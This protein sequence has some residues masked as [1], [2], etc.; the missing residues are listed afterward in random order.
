MGRRDQN[1]KSYPKVCVICSTQNQ[2]VNYI[3]LKMNK[4]DFG[5]IYNITV[6]GSTYF[7]NATWDK[8][9][10]A[11]LNKTFDDI[12]LQQG[13]THSVAKIL[14]NKQLESLKTLG[15]PIFW[16]ITGGQRTI[17]LS[18]MEIIKSNDTRNNDVIC[19]LE[20]NNNQMYISDIHHQKADVIDYS[21]EEFDLD[22]TKALKLG[23]F[24]ISQVKGDENHIDENSLKNFITEYKNTKNGL[25]DLMI[26]TNTNMTQDEAIKKLK[27]LSCQHKT[28]IQRVIEWGY[29]KNKSTPFGYILEEMTYYVIKESKYFQNIQELKTN[30]RLYN[31]EKIAEINNTQIDEFDVLLLTKNGKLMVFECKSGS[32]HRDIAKSTNYSTYAVSGVYGLPILITPLLQAEIPPKGTFQNLG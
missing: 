22:I 10:K 20:G 19:Y 14:E 26:E 7:N 21:K 16:N 18:I 28:E 24:A 12:S 3:P 2:M 11:T 1:N 17:L 15:S 23:G 31:D 25:R 6:A 9:L 5:T 4:F 30:V 13:D 32:M 8:N 29:T 27:T